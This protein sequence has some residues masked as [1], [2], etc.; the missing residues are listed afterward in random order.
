MLEMLVRVM[1]LLLLINYP[2]VSKYILL[3][4]SDSYLLSFGAPLFTSEF[5]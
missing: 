4:C 5:V 3:V 2:S 1:A